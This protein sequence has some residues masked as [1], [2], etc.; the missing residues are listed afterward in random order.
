MSNKIV[1][2]EDQFSKLKKNTSPKNNFNGFNEYNALLSKYNIVTPK[3]I[4]AFFSQIKIESKNFT[5]LSEQYNTGKVVPI[6]T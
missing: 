3:S 5:R 1:L 4:A 2:S 6:N